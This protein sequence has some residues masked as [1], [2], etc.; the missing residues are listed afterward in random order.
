MWKGLRKQRPLVPE[1]EEGWGMLEEGWGAAAVM[2]AA[3]VVVWERR[4]E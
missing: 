4:G 3:M 2:A 1:E